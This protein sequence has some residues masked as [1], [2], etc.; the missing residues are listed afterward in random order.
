MRL[1]GAHITNITMSFC[2]TFDTTFATKKGF[3]FTDF[4]PKHVLWSIVG[5]A[6]VVVVG[7][8]CGC[9]VN[10]MKAFYKKNIRAQPIRYININD[11]T[12]SA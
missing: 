2:P 3:F 8:I 11:D 7:M 12:N 1:S 9:L 6:G 5:V 10:V 4:K